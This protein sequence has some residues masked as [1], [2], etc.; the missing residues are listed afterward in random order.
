MYERILVPT[1]GSTGTAHVAMQA[2]DLAEQYDGTIYALNVVDTE[3]SSLLSDAGGDGERLQEQGESAVQVVERMAEGH[4]VDVETAVESGDPAET[5]LAYADEIDADVIVVGTHGRSGV[6][7]YVLGSVAERLVRHSTCPVLTVRLPESD[8]TVK[9]AD[10]AEEIVE[11]ALE[12]HG[13]DASVTGVNR[14]RNVWVVD[15]EGAGG[16]YLVYL[17][18]ITQRTSIIPQRH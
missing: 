10:E 4:D 17:D 3:V 1:D 2:I 12:S 7:R 14:Q 8:V 9:T 6:K 13:Y 5:I 16:T 18:P 15:A 11:H